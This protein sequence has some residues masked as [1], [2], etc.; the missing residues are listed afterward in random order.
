MDLL[1]RNN[2][3]PAKVVMGLGFYGRSFTLAD[4]S[5]SSPGCK[6]SA[7][8]N[9]GPCSATAGILLN[10]EI[11]DIIASGVTPTLDSDAAVKQIVWDSNQWVSFDDGDTLKTKLDWANSRCIGGTVVWAVS[12]DDSNATSSSEIGNLN[13]YLSKKSIWGGST[14]QQDS[15]SQ[16]VWGDCAPNGK[17]TCPGNLSP[18]V[19]GKGKGASNA[20]IYTGCPSGQS[21]NYC[22]PSDD[23]PTCKWVRPVLHCDYKTE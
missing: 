22:C 9:P 20:A 8:G 2:I 18:A 1:W 7:G 13:G 5:C 12:G 4:P 17:A 10:S 15:I 21:R 14:P 11:Q 6:F 19:T 23:V 16:C 3:D